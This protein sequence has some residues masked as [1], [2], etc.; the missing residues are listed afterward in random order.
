[1]KGLHQGAAHTLVS[2][3]GDQRGRLG[4]GHFGGKA[5]ATEYAGGQVGRGLS[6][7]FVRHQTDG[8]RA[9]GG[10]K[11][12]A[13]PR[14]R[15]AAV[16][17]L[18]QHG[19]QGGHWGSDDDH[20]GGGGQRCHVAADQHQLRRQGHIGQVARIAARCLQGGQL[21]RVAHPQRDGVAGR[22]GGGADGHRRTKSTRANNYYFHSC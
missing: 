20:V 1:M 22:V 18:C 7:D 6:A 21:L 4:A 14:Q 19:A 3:G 17:Q 13:Q 8:I 2:A 9:L 15:C 11:T 12:F 5:R 10:F 16:A